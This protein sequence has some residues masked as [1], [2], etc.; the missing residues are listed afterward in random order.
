MKLP[1]RKHGQR[2]IGR[3]NHDLGEINRIK[4]MKK[5]KRR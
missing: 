1:K 5:N 4:N 2:F 3:E